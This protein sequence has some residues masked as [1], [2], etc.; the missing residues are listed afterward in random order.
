M[1]IV[2]YIVTYYKTYSNVHCN[3]YVY[4]FFKRKIGY[5]TVIIVHK[6]DIIRTSSFCFIIRYKR[7]CIIFF[8]FFCTQMDLQD[9][10]KIFGRA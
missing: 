10:R 5:L 2:I 4:V 9:N 6:F 8:F 3:L 1:Y 7:Y